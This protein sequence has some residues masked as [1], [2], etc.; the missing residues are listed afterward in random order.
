MVFKR[1]DKP[2]LWDRLREVLSPR[3]GWRR[4]FQY[5]GKRIQRLPDT[6][7]RIAL[8]FA[9]GAL[10]SFTPFFGLHFLVAAAF[11]WVIG[12]N[13]ISSA[14]GTIVGNPLTFPFIAG[15]SLKVGGT[16][17]A[18]PSVEGPQNFSFGY[19]W[20]NIADIF[21]P[22]LVGGVV[23]GILCGAACYW[24][25]RPVVAAYQNRR[26]EKLMDLAKR[27]FRE[28]ASRLPKRSP[29]RPADVGD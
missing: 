10:A 19:L 18:F 9:C 28:H 2:P 3:K 25:I 6:P 26:R 24:F 12:G 23:P 4:G 13:L 11:A 20:S 15:V 14:I 27:K 5:L 8:G 1:R 16:I 22:Y 17:V 29:V 7:H 21:V